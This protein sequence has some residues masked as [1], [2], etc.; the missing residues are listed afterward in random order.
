MSQVLELEEDFSFL[1]QDSFRDLYH[2]ENQT[3][4][5]RFYLE[6]IRCAK[7]VRKLE[8]LPLS[9]EGLKSLRV[10]M[11]SSTLEAEVDLAKLTFHQL[12]KV[13]VKMGFKPQPLNG[14]DREEQIR[15][16]EDKTALIRLAV[17]GFCAGNIMMFS[18][19]NYFGDTGT[20]KPIFLTLSFILYL[21][22]LTF[23][24]WPFYKTAWLSL[25]K[26]EI[27]L[28]CQWQWPP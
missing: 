26:H 25:R 8:D 10:E 20:F 23:V 2:L 17:A 19:A 16:N 22:V 13:F 5:M 18:F 24:A 9:L 12:A 28:I 6:G 27:S 7:C 21:P 3:P 14:R 15:R 11:G 1:D 4:K